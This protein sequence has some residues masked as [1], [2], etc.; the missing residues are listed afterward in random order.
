[1]LRTA[2]LSTRANRNYG[3][4]DGISTGK[5]ESQSHARTGATR[6]VSTARHGRFKETAHDARERDDT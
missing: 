1:M 5:F 3:P 6:I 4:P 2:M